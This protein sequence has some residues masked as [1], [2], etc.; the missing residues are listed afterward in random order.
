MEDA[1]TPAPLAGL[2]FTGTDTG[3]GKTWVAAAVARHLRR[4]G[5]PIA[6][7][8]PVATGAAWR[9]GK[10]RSEDTRCLAEAAGL[11]HELDRITPWAF[12]EPAAPPV[13]AR[14]HGVT[15]TL[16]GLAGAVRAWA[17]PGVAVLVEG[18]GGLLC[19]VTE[20]ETVANLAASLRLPLVVVTRRSLGTLNHTL[21]TLEVAR[22]RGLLVAALVVNETTPPEGLAAATNIGEL[23]RRVD[24]PLRAVV[25]YRAPGQPPDER[26]LD[27][28]DWWRLCH[29]NRTELPLN[30]ESFRSWQR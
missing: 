12:P 21:L 2:L 20:S 11:S 26:A 16:E 6:V 5:R 3:V 14:C 15:L 25:P 30:E 28:V 24:V 22:Q 17:Q 23:A 1:A 27:A 19:P 18:I 10:W 4:Q 7:C 29:S 13:A 9:E 8:K